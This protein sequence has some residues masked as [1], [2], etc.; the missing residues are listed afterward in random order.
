MSFLADPPALVVVGA[1]LHRWV[2]EERAQRWA[3]RAT[4]VTFVGT[5]AALY[6]NAGWTRPLWRL[7][8]ASSGR[9]WMLNSGVFHLDHEHPAVRTHAFAVS[10]FCTY[11]LWLRLGCRLG[12]KPSHA[13]RARDPQ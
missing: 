8:G 12:R 9:D 10:A 13:S 5:S 11:P 6:L 1:A 4:L 3:R 2:P 7:L